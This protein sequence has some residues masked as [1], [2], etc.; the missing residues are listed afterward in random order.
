[1]LTSNAWC[2]VNVAL[3]PFDKKIEQ[4]KKKKTKLTAIKLE[5]KYK[6]YG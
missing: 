3:V 4:K 6:S 1:M 2:F 5:K